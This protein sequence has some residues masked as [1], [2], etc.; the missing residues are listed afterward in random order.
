MVKREVL[1][2]INVSTSQVQ[3]LLPGSRHREKGYLEKGVR[4]LYLGCCTRHRQIARLVVAIDPIIGR[5]GDVLGEVVRD[6]GLFVGRCRYDRDGCLQRLNGLGDILAKLGVAI[7]ENS[8]LAA[9]LR[10][11]QRAFRGARTSDS[12]G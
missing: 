1:R 3:V 2:Q 11:C 9:D 4:L 10:W 6:R 12:V 7:A 8:V 5:F